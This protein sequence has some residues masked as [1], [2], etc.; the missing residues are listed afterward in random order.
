MKQLTAPT[1]V[2]VVDVGGS[3]VKCL[4]SG[5][6]KRRKFDSWPE[7]SA[8]QMVERALKLVADWPFDAVSLGYPGAVVG[9][10]PA[11]EPHNLGRGWVG[12][13]FERAFAR[14]VKVLNDSAMQ[15]YG[16]YRGGKMLY[17]G[18]GTGLGSALIADHVILPLELAHLPY[19]KHG[20]YEDYVGKRGLERLGEAD[21]LDE[22]EKVIELFRRALLPDYIVLGGG[23]ADRIDKP[24]AAVSLVDN[25]AAFLGGFRLWEA[26]RATVETGLA[27]ERGLAAAGKTH[28]HAI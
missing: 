8:A 7:M 6:V 4:V 9:N 15:A 28:G 5:Q 25:R 22:V 21:W 23:N 26:S 19:K 12:F 16:A 14:P 13:D 3:H 18:L 2:L 10:Q 11:R 1:R 20:S 27:L 17:L 24:L